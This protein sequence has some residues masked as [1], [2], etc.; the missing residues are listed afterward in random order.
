[1]KKYQCLDIRGE[2]LKNAKPRKK[3]TRIRKDSKEAAQR[4]AIHCGRGKEIYQ[5]LSKKEHRADAWALG[6]EEGRDKLRKAAGRSKYPM[7]RG[8]PNGETHI[9]RPYV[10][11]SKSIA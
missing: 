9:R 1:M 5:R 4:N 6:A 11:L 8:Y 2:A 10:P 7:I 3:Q